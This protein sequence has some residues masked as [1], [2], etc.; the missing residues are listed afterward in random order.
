MPKGY[1]QHPP[2]P[3]PPPFRHNRRLPNHPPTAAH[4]LLH[5]AL[6]CWWLLLPPKNSSRLQLRV[7]GATSIVAANLALSLLLLARGGPDE[8][9]P[10]EKIIADTTIKHRPGF[11]ITGACLKSTQSLAIDYLVISWREQ[12]QEL[13]Y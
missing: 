8:S 13:K 11:I 3:P 7:A 12:R 4:Y 5:G 2:P 10:Q 1:I 6:R 9:L